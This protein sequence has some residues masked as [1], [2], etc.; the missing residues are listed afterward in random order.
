MTTA[1]AQTYAREGQD[2]GDLRSRTADADR[3]GRVE[4]G[5]LPSYQADVL[6]RMGELAMSGR[7]AESKAMH[8]REFEGAR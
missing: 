1:T 5:E 7:L 2:L 6:E 3:A 4:R 8:R